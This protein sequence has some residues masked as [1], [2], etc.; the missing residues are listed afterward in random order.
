LAAIYDS[1]WIVVYGQALRALPWILLLQ[2]SAWSRVAASR[3]EAME[4]EGAGGLAL[5]WRL[6]WGSHRQAMAVSFFAAWA[7]AMSELPVTKI[8]APPGFDPLSV[9]VFGLLH[10]GTSN[11]QAALVLG[12]I[13]ITVVLVSLA[14]ARIRR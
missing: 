11:E 9:R 2:G 1:P 4:L 3:W 10:V 13:L 5:W 8:V 14:L 7:L 12:S 6:L